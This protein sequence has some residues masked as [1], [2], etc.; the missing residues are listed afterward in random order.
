MEAL[1]D[2]VGKQQKSEGETIYLS[3]SRKQRDKVTTEFLYLTAHCKKDQTMSN[4]FSELL[5]RIVYHVIKQ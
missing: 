5:D 1:L 3:L 2:Y 4:A